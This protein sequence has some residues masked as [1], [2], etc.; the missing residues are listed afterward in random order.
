MTARPSADQHLRPLEIAIV[1]SDLLIAA[2][3]GRPLQVAHAIH[4]CGYDLVIP[5]SWG[6][7]LVARYGLEALDQ[8]GSRPM[9]FSACPKVRSRLMASGTELLPHLISCIAPPAA[10]ARYLRALQPDLRLRVTYIGGCP[11][12]ADTSIDV[13]IRLRSF[14]Q[15]SRH[16]GSLC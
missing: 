3:P 2:L 12:A 14:S 7:E 5:A 15:L 1:G 9:V 10:T 6:D 13:R 11:G 4:A 16:A 8:A